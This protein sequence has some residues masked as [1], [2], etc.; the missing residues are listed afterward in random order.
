MSTDVQGS[1]YTWALDNILD[2][3]EKMC[4]V[5]ELLLENFSNKS[6]GGEGA[7]DVSSPEGREGMWGSSARLWSRTYSR[8]SPTTLCHTKKLS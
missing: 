8:L 1:A 3:Q 2:S 6:H 7:V 4:L 5:P